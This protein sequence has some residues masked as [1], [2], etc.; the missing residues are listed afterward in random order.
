MSSKWEEGLWLGHCRKSNEV[1]IGTPTKAVKAWAVRRR[2]AEERWDK[3][4]V[5]QLRA[6]PEDPQ[7]FRSDSSGVRSAED[8]PEEEPTTEEE[9]VEEKN[10][11]LKLRARDFAR[12]GHSDE[13][14]GCARMRR[15]AKPP[16]Q[17]NQKCR[18]RLERLIKG[19]D[20]QQWERDCTRTALGST[21][22]GNR[23]IVGGGKCRR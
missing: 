7:V 19:E 22:R 13:C 1:W 11:H 4:A 18:R 9:E 2:I 23:G 16:S 12:H 3:H 15:G 6:A 5:S 20:P 17:H 14:A 10:R 21:A 8:G